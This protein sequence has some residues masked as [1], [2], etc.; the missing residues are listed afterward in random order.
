MQM[1]WQDVAAAA[2]AAGRRN[3]DDENGVEVKLVG[4]GR[5]P[6][7]WQLFSSSS[8]EAAHGN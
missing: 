1:S 6:V 4:G 3:K 8:N 5:Y 2:A 7:D